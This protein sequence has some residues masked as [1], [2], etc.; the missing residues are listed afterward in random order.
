MMTQSERFRAIFSRQKPDR[1][2]VLFFGA[3]PATKLRWKAEGF[4]ITNDIGHDYGPEIP[5]MDPDWEYDIWHCHGIADIGAIGTFP[6]EVISET[7]TQRIRRTSVGALLQEDKTSGGMSR[8][9]EHALAPGR[10]AWERF[11]RFLDPKDPR[12]WAA[13]W[14]ARAEKLRGTDKIKAFVGGSLYGWLRDWLGVEEISYLMYDDP[15]LFEEMVAYMADYFMEI[16][17]PV[18]YQVDFDFVY[19]FEDCCGATGPLFSPEIYRAVLDKHYRRLIRFYKDHGV[20]LAL[21]DSDGFVEPLVPCWLKSGFDIIFPI[22]VG[23]WQAS[24]AAMREKFGKDMMM[25][26]GV[27]KH[28]IPEGEA[29]IRRHLLALKP[30]VDEGGYLPIPDHRIPPDCSYAQFQ[31]YIRV[32]NEVFNSGSD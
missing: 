4:Q 6:E 10:E 7:E 31:T 8:H 12:H 32:F 13:D 22:E 5:G 9:L 17:E 18:L 21:I 23:K 28:V 19:I 25:F 29:A 1:I 20:P 30:A 27:D 14:E 24:P 11:K 26:G 16:F 2:P 3:W 15:E